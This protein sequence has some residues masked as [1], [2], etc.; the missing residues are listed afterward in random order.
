MQHVVILDMTGTSVRGTEKDGR[1]D[2]SDLA[3]FNAATV[4]MVDAIAT[5]LA[6]VPGVLH[7][8]DLEDPDGMLVWKVESARGSTPRQSLSTL[9]PARSTS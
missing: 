5:A 3:D 7:N 8:A 4:E 1:L 6:S 9:S 2:S